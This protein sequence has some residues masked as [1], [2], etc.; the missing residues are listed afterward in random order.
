MYQCVFN[1][2]KAAAVGTKHNTPSVNELFPDENVLSVVCL[3]CNFET[4]NLS[5]N[6]A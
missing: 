2:H 4:L 1:W 5:I 6:T 3:V